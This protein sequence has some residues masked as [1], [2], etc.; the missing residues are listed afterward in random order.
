MA[1]DLNVQV[2]HTEEPRTGQEYLGDG[3]YAEFDGY[4]IWLYTQI[5]DSRLSEIALEP[6]VFA[7]LLNY[8][9][10]IRK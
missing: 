3:V 7:H 1:D 9:E 6:G 4:R 10:K 2:I 5:G 8:A